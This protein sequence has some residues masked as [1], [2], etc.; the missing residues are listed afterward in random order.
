MELSMELQVLFFGQTRFGNN[1]RFDTEHR[2]GAWGRSPALLGR[3]ERSSPKCRW[4][5]APKTRGL[6]AEAQAE[7]SSICRD[8]HHLRALSERSGTKFYT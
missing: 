4:R 3:A 8:A 6:R 2:R 7:R 5:R 1:V